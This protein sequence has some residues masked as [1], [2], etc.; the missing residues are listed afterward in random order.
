[1]TLTLDL[2]TWIS[3]GVIYS[4]RTIYLPS[5]KL[6][7]QSVLELSV[8]QGEVDWQFWHDLW[9]WPTDLNVNR[10]HLHIKDYLRTKF[11][12][13][14]AKHSWVYQL[15]KVRGYRHTDRHVQSNMPLL[16]QRGHKCWGKEGRLIE[17]IT[18]LWK[19]QGNPIRVSMI[20]C[21]KSWTRGWDSLVPSTMWWLIIF[22]PRTFQHRFSCT[23]HSA[24]APLPTT[25]S[26]YWLRRDVIIYLALNDGAKMLSHP[27]LR[28][29]RMRQHFPRRAKFGYRSVSSGRKYIVIIIMC[30]EGNG[31]FFSPEARTVARGQ[32]FLSRGWQ[33]DRCP[34]YTYD[35]YFI[36]PIQ[37]INFKAI[38]LSICYDIGRFWPGVQSSISL[39]Q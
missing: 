12:A 7:G 4:S 25:T 15:N 19:G 8:A 32:Q 34:N 5:L 29:H 39:A 2:L 10:G 36:T 30:I 24:M 33:A 17:S 37:K 22:L 26:W 16:L 9:P 3:I 13:S 38:A 11:E 31:Q 35:N 27:R 23:K 1:M 6:L 28:H 18:T 20:G 14:S 21:C